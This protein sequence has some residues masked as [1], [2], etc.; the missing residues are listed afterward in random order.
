MSLGTAPCSSTPFIWLHIKKS[1]GQSIRQ[2]LS[3]PY[4]ETRR[5]QARPFSA[6]PQEEWNDNLNNF[7][8]PLGE[9]DYRR[10]LFARDFLYPRDFH[11]R[12]KFAIVR[13]P[14]ARIV[15]AWKYLTRRGII[16]FFWP[17]Y[18][19]RHRFEN[20]LAILPVLWESKWNRQIATHTAP[21]WPD[22]TDENGHLLL[23]FIGHLED[24]EEDFRVIFRR[25]SLSSLP[26][27]PLENANI[28]G[29]Q[30]RQAYTRKT[31]RLVETLYGEDI[32]RLGYEFE[33]GV[34]QTAAADHMR[35][36]K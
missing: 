34:V 35:H 2:A 33:G 29:Q 14:Y 12:F 26:S 23:D 19:Y 11:S 24:I 27:F 30:H 13:N 22:I 32:E 3:S 28:H 7:R 9:Y 1:G 21:V 20:F 10:M 6:L 15:S 5:K 17:R 18:L 31:R 36:G 4:V 8:I 16:T 25:L